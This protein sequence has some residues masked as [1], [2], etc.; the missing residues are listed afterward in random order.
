MELYDWDMADHINTKEEVFAYLEGALEENDME[1]LF[2][3]IGAIVRSKGMAKIAQEAG[4]NRESLYK[5]LSR[6]GNPSFATIAK[7][8]DILGYKIEIKQKTA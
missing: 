6:D 5:S 8:V 4:L 7:V 1:T 2:D 3:V